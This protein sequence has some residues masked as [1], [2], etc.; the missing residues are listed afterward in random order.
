M[1]GSK[2]HRKIRRV[3]R[4]LAQEKEALNDAETTSRK[5]ERKEQ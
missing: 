2:L 5:Q 1:K 4:D 3:Y